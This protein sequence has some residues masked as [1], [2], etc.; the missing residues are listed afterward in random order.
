M[1]DER[2]LKLCGNTFFILLQ[3]IKKENR[4]CYSNNEKLER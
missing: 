4:V 2:I 1:E 3:A